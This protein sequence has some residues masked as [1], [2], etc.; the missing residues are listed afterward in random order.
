MRTL[1][2]RQWHPGYKNTVKPHMEE[3]I[4]WLPADRF[5]EWM[6]FTGLLDRNG[7]EI[8]EGDIVKVQGEVREVVFEDYAWLTKKVYKGRGGHTSLYTLADNEKYQVIGNIYESGEL[9]K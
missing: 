7:K 2:F 8:Y 5:G 6:Q 1:K 3:P 4:D 9:L